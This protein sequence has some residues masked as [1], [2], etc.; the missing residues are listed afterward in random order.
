METSNVI[1]LKLGTYTLRQE[2]RKW[3]KS[4][5]LDQT[6]SAIYTSHFTNLNTVPVNAML[7]AP[8]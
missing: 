3:W 6:G 5:M 8:Y 2:Y 1:T 7:K 4:V